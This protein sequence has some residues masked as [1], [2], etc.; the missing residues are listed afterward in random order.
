MR[1]RYK[2]VL[3]LIEKHKYIQ[4]SMIAQE[5]FR[6]P[7]GKVKAQQVLK[8]MT[9]EGIINRFRVG[10]RTDYIYYTGKR[11]Q[12]WWHWLELSRF[13]FTLLQ[14]LKQWQRII[15]F[16]T[17]VRYPFGIADAF[18]IIKLTIDGDGL[19]FF[20]EVDDG[21]NNFDKVIK[22]LNYYKGKSWRGEWWGK[23]GFPYVLVVTP[24]QDSIKYLISKSE[25]AEE[26]FRVSPTHEGSLETLKG[27]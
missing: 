16:E 12:K 15:Y 24:R 21:Q 20:L 11:S 6:F 1:K 27:A 2:D 23:E 26:I 18:Y 3:S 19:M 10:S 5:L 8:R 9:E 25:G 17:E 22:Y 13:H 7:T 14:E 4:T